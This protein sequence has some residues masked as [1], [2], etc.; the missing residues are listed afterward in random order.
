[1]SEVVEAGAAA[2]KIAEEHVV[3]QGEKEQNDARP[4]TAAAQ[5]SEEEDEVRLHLSSKP[6]EFWDTDQVEGWLQRVKPDHVPVTSVFKMRKWTYCFVTIKKEHEEEF[7]EAVNGSLLKKYP[8][9][10]RKGK[11][12]VNDWDPS[13]NPVAKK[14]KNKSHPDYQPT[15]WEI[16]Q[17]LKTSQS[18][19][20]SLS[21]KTAPLSIYTYEEQLKMKDTYAKTAARSFTKSMKILCGR[22]GWKVPK[23]AKV[24]HGRV[25]CPFE[26]IIATKPEVVKRGYRN[27]CEFTVG[28]DPDGK[29][30][31]GFVLRILPSAGDQVVGS[32]MDLPH[33]PTAMKTLID[34]LKVVIQ[35]PKLPIYDRSKGNHVGVWRIFTIRLVEA[36]SDDEEPSVLILVQTG[37]ITADEETRIRNLMMEHVIK[38]E[39]PQVKSVYIQQNPKVSD[40]PEPDAKIGVL[41]GAEVLQMPLCGLTFELG[42]TSFFQA[43]SSTC[44]ALYDKAIEWVQPKELLLDICCGVGTIGIVAAKKT[45][46]SVIGI[47][48]VRE[49]CAAARRN[50][51]NNNVDFEVHEGKVEDLLPGILKNLPQNKDI[52]AIVDPPR[53]GLH[54]NVLLALRNCAEIKRLVYISCNP[55]SL[56][57]D[58]GKLCHPSGVPS[59]VF[60]PTRAVAVDMFPHTVHCEMILQLDR[61]DSTPDET[62]T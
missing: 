44:E 18:S 25:G 35:D 38:P 48:L 5:Q 39:G 55:E 20:M 10:V 32:A 43:N 60:R 33:V 2:D 6:F 16:K 12:R 24:G 62:E 29:P 53:G 59:E 36:K 21:E 9:E 26:E 42:P 61:L 1:M 8:V 30:E 17:K 40:A 7:T 14:Q 27:K 41:C 28:L 11:K 56:A 58:V 45:G 4:K 52:V 37:N 19:K 31:I 46:C 51:H 54:G 22:E 57:L 49:S 34:R 23:W 3:E 13:F 47:E 15:I 50:A